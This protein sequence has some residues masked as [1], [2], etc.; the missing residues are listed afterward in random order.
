MYP[1]KWAKNYQWTYVQKSVPDVSSAADVLYGSHTFQHSF[2]LFV[3]QRC[4]LSK[5]PDFTQIFWQAFSTH[6]CNTSYYWSTLN[7]PTSLDVPIAFGQEIKVR[8]TC[9]PVDWASVS[10]S[11]AAWQCR[12]NELVPHNAR[13]TCIVI[14]EE[15]HVPRVLVT[16]HQKTMVHC[17]C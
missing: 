12:E 16:V 7:T 13:L 2:Q 10:C 6:C 11:G 9:G 14:D 1:L 3:V 17:T 4:T 15:A 5:I 8:E